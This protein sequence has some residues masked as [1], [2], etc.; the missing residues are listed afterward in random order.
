MSTKINMTKRKFKDPTALTPYEQS[1]KDLVD[2]GKSFEQI[3]QELGKNK[4]ESISH[5][6]KTIREKLECA[7]T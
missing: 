4:P 3:A 1:I 7:G 5:R 6:Y 2:Q